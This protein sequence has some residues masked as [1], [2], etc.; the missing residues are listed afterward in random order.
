L[1]S[2]SHSLISRVKCFDGFIERYSHE[3]TTLNCKMH[4][5]V[6][7]PPLSSSKNNIFPVLY[8]LSGLTCTDENFIIK[9]GAQR[10]ASKC[11]VFLVC[12]DTSP[13]HI[14]IEGQD[15]SWD[16][17][18]GAGFYLSATEP[19]WAHNYQMYSYVTQELPNL[20]NSNFPVD[21]N[22]QSIFGHSMGGHGALICALKNPGKYKSVTAFA[23]ICNPVNCPWGDKAFTG[24]LGNDKESWK[25]W[26]ASELVKKYQGPDLH[27]LIDQGT[28]DKF[29]KEKQLLPEAFEEA[30]KQSNQHVVVRLQEGYDHS[31]HFISTFIGAHIEHHASFLSS[32]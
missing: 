13:R 31:Y 29:W 10:D 21:S 7:I 4:F 32:Q 27:L 5:T 19:K 2:M 11:G 28:E 14:H 23:P 30:C 20:I 26:D 1:Q 9:S 24:Y 17:G 12:P 8:W 3:S 15:E 25:N 16:F 6:F 22:R 18:S